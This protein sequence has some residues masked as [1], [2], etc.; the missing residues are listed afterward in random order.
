MKLFTSK[1]SI[2]LYLLG[3][4]SLCCTISV[5]RDLR[6]LP[7]SFFPDPEST[8]VPIQSGR[9]DLASAVYQSPPGPL[10]SHTPLEHGN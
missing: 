7:P 1:V 10:V 3:I 6:L 4:V 2:S 5:H 9:Y 8:L